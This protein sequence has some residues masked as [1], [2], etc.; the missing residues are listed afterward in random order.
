MQSKDRTINSLSAVLRALASMKLTVVCLLLLVIIVFWGTLYQADYGLYQAQQKFFYSWVFFIFG[1]IPFPGTVLVMVILTLNLI[2]S[3]FYRIGFKLSNIGNAI[4]HLGLIIL[5]FGGGL[6]FFFSVESTLMLVEGQ[7]RNRSEAR[8]R[9]EVALWTESGE[10]KDIYALDV[11]DIQRTRITE[12]PELGIHL[13]RIDYFPNSTAVFQK[14]HEKRIFLNGSGVG[15]IRPA[16]PAMEASEN[17][18]GITLDIDAGT[19]ELKLLLYGGDRNSTRI[20]HNG[21]TIFFKLRKKQY[22]LPISVKLRDVTAKKYP[23][24]EIV[25]SYAS[26]VEIDD[27]QGGKRD[28]RISMNK[29]L[30]YS[31]LTFFQSGYHKTP[32]GIEYSYFQVVKNSGRLLPYV[33]SLFIFVGLVIHFIVMF[34]RRRKQN[35]D[36]E[37]IK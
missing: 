6:T 26:I 2:S 32:Q 24:S 11:Q 3:L 14:S 17:I 12:I 27:G 34:F 29:P 33:S 10:Q 20:D 23:N 18:A 15:A 22:L 1:F 4:T 36:T 30:R 9:W 8:D 37:T 7:A 21:K 13:S 19:R 5:L 35:T 25:K 28:V 16:K 31:N